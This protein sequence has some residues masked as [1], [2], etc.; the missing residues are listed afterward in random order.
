MAKKL[1]VTTTTNWPEHVTK[2]RFCISKFQLAARLSALSN[3]A[4]PLVY[5]GVPKRKLKRARETLTTV[6]LGERVDH[7]QMKCQAD[8]GKS[9]N[10]QSF[11]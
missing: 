4:L 9:G 10:C 2:N 5:A 6:G 3:V 1:A 8:K 11:D 7:S